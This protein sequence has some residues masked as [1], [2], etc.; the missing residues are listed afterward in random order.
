MDI[1]EEMR[2]FEI[3]HE[4]EGWPAVKMRQISA[5]CDEIDRLRRRIDA[6]P[7]AIMDTRDVLGIC[8]PTEEDFPSLYA[9]Q[10]KRVR[11]VLENIPEPSNA[12]AQGR[13]HSER[14]AGAEG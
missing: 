8:A 13:E 14:P 1:V 5:L 4:P 12:L 6:A 10:G 3:D 2:G 7:L 11:L 9:L